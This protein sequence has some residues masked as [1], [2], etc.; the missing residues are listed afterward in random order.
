MNWPKAPQ[1]LL[2][3]SNQVHARTSKGQLFDSR[4]AMHCTSGMTC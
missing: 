2:G 1:E 4:I 3:D